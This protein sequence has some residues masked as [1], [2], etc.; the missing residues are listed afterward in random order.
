MMEYINALLNKTS[1]LEDLKT[2]ED[3]EKDRPYCHHDFEHLLAVARIASLMAQ[4]NHAD[5]AKE[6][7]Y[8]AAL[9]HDMGRIEEYQNKGEHHLASVNRAKKYFEQIGLPA[10][11]Q[12]LILKAIGNH[13]HQEDDAIGAFSLLLKKADKLSRN[14]FICPAKE[15]CYWS[16]E[17]KNHSIIY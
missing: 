3:L 6:D 12:D 11:R 7:I 5:F 2:L 8:L 4:E 13:R 9:L 1:Y 10:C 15:S 17:K 14:C 16:D